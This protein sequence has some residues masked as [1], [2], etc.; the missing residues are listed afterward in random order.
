MK[1]TTER[2]KDL[3]TAEAAASALFRVFFEQRKRPLPRVQT[4]GYRN[5]VA[6]PRME[7]IR[8]ENNGEAVEWAVQVDGVE[9]TDAAIQVLMSSEQPKGEPE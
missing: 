8:A 3:A 7:C 4:I 1:I 5:G 6:R 2:F 9:L